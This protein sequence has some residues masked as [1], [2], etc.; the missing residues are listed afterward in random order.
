[1]SI[2]EFNL[3]QNK[4]TNFN[5]LGPWPWVFQIVLRQGVGEMIKFAW[6][7]FL[8]GGGNLARN[9]FEH[10]NLFQSYEPLRMS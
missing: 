1:M 2:E 3:S 7:V 10:S 5:K 9:D 6:G 8:L 4:L